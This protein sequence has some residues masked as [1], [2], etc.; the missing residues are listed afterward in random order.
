MFDGYLYAYCKLLV[1]LLI[2]T[3][4]PR[5][6][7]LGNVPVFS[8]LRRVQ[9]SGNLSREAKLVSAFKLDPLAGNSGQSRR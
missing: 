4:E 6:R 1:F 2:I 8:Y 5:R 9:G 3:A 7:G